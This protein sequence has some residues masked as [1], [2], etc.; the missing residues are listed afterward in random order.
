MLK[1]KLLLSILSLIMIFSMVCTGF[2][3]TVSYDGDT[4]L[5]NVNGQL[6]AAWLR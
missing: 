6:D 1:K 2:A 3:A 5:V 4:E